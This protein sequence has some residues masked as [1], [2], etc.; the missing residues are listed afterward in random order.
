MTIIMEQHQLDKLLA[1]ERKKAI[2][3]C[4]KVCD[5]ICDEY[6]KRECRLYPEMRTDAK[7]GSDDCAYAIRL[8]L[9]KE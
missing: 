3:E 2:E 6:D 1:D 5:D 7:T 8:L 4:A 9:E